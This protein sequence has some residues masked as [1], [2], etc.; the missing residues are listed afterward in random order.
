MQM[1]NFTAHLFCLYA[2]DFHCL[3]VV[4]HNLNHPLHHVNNPKYSDLTQWSR[5]LLEKPTVPQ[6]VTKFPAFYGTRRFIA[7]L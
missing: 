7:A 3:R 2:I 4:K 1:N 5:I 6:L